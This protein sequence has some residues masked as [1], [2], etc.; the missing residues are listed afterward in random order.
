MEKIN[1]IQTFCE[2][3]KKKY[4]ALTIPM[5]LP[6]GH[7]Y[8]E[9]CLTNYYSENQKLICFAEDKAFKILIS[10]LK[11]PYD[12]YK[13]RIPELSN[14]SYVCSKHN[15]EMIKF[16]CDEHKEFMCCL[17][18]WDHSNHKDSTRIYLEEDLINDLGKVESKLKEISNV[19]DS[20]NS[21][22][23]DI[24]SKKI[25]KSEEIKDFFILAEKFILTPYAS[26][27]D[28]ENI[29][30]PLVIENNILKTAV[31]IKKPNIFEES[32]LASQIINGDYLKKLFS[33]I[34]IVTKLL[35]RASRDGFQVDKFHTLCDD[36][37]PT[38]T[39][40]KSKNGFFFG[41]YNSISWG[42]SD[43]TNNGYKSAP[44]S[45]LF[46]L[47]N[48]T[49][50][51]ICRNETSAIYLDQK[52]GPTFGGGHDFRIYTDCNVN[53][54]SY[55]NLGYTF[56]SPFDYQSQESRNYLAGIYN[57]QVEDYEVFLISLE[58]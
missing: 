58:T 25:N 2:N 32:I 46:S 42:N 6:C 14:N 3:C 4:D 7:Y 15:K 17:C 29:R 43:N 33:G 10:A 16:I 45:Y 30:F 8:C 26:N 49:K 48:R 13:M 47:N 9:D 53:T 57:F 44:G 39:L 34:N 56:K 5:E 18:M 38:V 35:Y 37:G 27:I 22:I 23:Q 41:G 12:Y 20:L 24:R 40:V 11:I 36:K 1:E 52:Y 21:K 55:S 50:H 51:E 31:E 28:T 54:K 19:L